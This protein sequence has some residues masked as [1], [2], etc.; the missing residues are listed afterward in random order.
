M[1]NDMSLLYR[2][3]RCAVGIAL[4]L[5]LVTGCYDH[6]SGITPPPPPPSGITALVAEPDNAFA[7]SHGV[8]V[9]TW[10]VTGPAGSV[11]DIFPTYVVGTTAGNADGIPGFPATPAPG[12]FSPPV[13]ATTP[14]VLS[15]LIIPLGGVLNGSFSWFAG[16]DLGFIGAICT[17]HLTTVSNGIQGGSGSSPSFNYT[18]GLP[19]QSA[20]GPIA[21][22]L[23]PGGVGTG[24]AGHTANALPNS[25]NLRQLL[26]AGG[27]GSLGDA[28]DSLDR[29]VFDPSTYL[30]SLGNTA[31]GGARAMH[32]SSFFLEP[33]IGPT[34]GELRVLVCG[35]AT[36]ENSL[37]PTTAGYTLLAR[38]LGQ[39]N[40]GTGMIYTPSPEGISGA[41]NPMGQARFAHT[42]TWVPS[43]AIIIIG[44]A[45]IA[46]AV[47]NAT[48]TVES[49]DP[50]SSTFS[51]VGAVNI[52]R[53]E[54][55]ATLLANGKILVV[56]GYDP[57]APG[58]SL[59]TAELYNPAN[60]SSTVLNSANC[61]NVDV[62]TAR[63]GHSA[64]RL[65]NG[66]VLVAGGRSPDT[67]NMLNTAFLYKPENGPLGEFVAI[68]NLPSPRA[69][70]TATFL[71]NSTV[72]LAG[73]LW[74]DTFSVESF[75]KDTTLFL[76]P[77]I[78][79]A[80]APTTFTATATS[81]QL[82]LARGMHTSTAMPGGNVLVVG[83]RN[84]TTAG[85][86]YI[87]G[88][89]EVFAFSNQVPV[90]SVPMSSANA[91][92]GVVNINFTVS[93][94]DGDGGFVV[95]RFRPAASSTWSTATIVSQSPLS[96]GITTPTM[97]VAPGAVSMA[98]NYGADGVSSGTSV[99]VEVMPFGATLGTP[100]AVT[101]TVQ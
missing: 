84:S 86:P 73:G 23:P 97:E 22:P 91:T 32:A 7:P 79:S 45:S 9:F 33:A 49:F 17:F 1:G 40:V 11:I 24:R 38:A 88:N 83:G 50:T 14:S 76:L 62:A 77:S 66:W 16:A 3:G 41:S 89:T 68:S 43:N 30:L 52:T 35:G 46:G 54:H 81:S 90:V 80:S 12:S 55:S 37:D 48:S 19:A 57:T 56:G 44:G 75:T 63:C 87:A 29:L 61:P 96:P 101:F 64:T 5:T 20:N 65:A 10:S 42:A 100:M 93:D 25:G 99:Q 98:W 2:S 8:V 69:L 21:P 27:T 92:A 18:S 85:A 71:D 59:T 31:L 34:N 28:Y 6:G 53:A 15:G 74:Q 4:V 78:F 95:V 51:T 60:G 26:I 13:P 67:G 94:V 82:Q 70:H 58:A 39:G 36:G 72:M 47:L